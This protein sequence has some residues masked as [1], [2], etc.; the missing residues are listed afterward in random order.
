VDSATK[1]L[2][3]VRASLD[4]ARRDAVRRAVEANV[5]EHSA[6][7]T[8][9]PASASTFTV[10]GAAAAARAPAATPLLPRPSPSLPLQAPPPLLSRAAAAPVGAIRPAAARPASAPVAAAPSAAAPPP[11]TFTPTPALHDHRRR[12]SATTEE[13][14]RS[15]QLPSGP[16]SPDF[17]APANSTRPS[18]AG[19]KS[20]GSPA[21][22]SGLSLAD[23]VKRLSAQLHLSA[24]AAHL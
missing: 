14:E 7:S 16:P 17:A 21:S 10:V 13:P 4:G 2:V 15:G 11:A 5:V 20:G 24:R 9:G 8:S 22:L 6:V 12:P 1:A 18:G 19:R 23:E 3:Q